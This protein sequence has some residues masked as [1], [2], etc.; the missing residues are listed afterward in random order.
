MN[1]LKLAP[2]A[3]A[4][5]DAIWSYTA[6]NWNTDQAESYIRNLTQ[7]MRTL[8]QNPALGKAIDDVRPGYLKF[9]TGSHVIYYRRTSTGID[10][11]RLLHK[12]MDADRHI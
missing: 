8:A 9:P 12:R 2:A 3:R 10:V 5:L 7:A 4:D 11:I 6:K 1:R